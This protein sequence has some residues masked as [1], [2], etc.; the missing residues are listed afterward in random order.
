M[1]IGVPKETFPGERRVALIPAVLPQLAKAQMQ[2]LLERGA[3]TAAGFAD[4]EYE[5]KGARIAATRRDV[6]D[7]AG[8][9]AQ[10]RTPGAN[11]ATGRDDIAL[12]NPGTVIVGLAEPL[13][14]LDT[15]RTLA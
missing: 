14:E 5:Q 3:G 1:I 10:V 8:V 11:L 9:I 6:F 4:A 2:V 15:V 12:L 7:Q 13:V